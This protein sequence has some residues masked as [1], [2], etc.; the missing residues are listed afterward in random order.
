VSGSRMVRR[1]M[2]VR[3]TY[4]ENVKNP[5]FPGFLWGEDRI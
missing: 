1:W 5:D 2:T 3:R 4:V